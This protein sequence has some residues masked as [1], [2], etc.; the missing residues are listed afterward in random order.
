MGYAGRTRALIASQPQRVCEIPTFV[1]VSERRRSQW[2][3]QNLH[4]PI[5]SGQ[6]LFTLGKSLYQECNI[7]DNYY[8]EVSA[9][10][11]IVTYMY[12]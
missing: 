8:V 5:L 12:T 10:G 7:V 3:N 4:V 2:C 6:T 1:F 9:S 11:Y